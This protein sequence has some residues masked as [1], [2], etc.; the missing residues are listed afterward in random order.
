[1]ITGYN[2]PTKSKTNAILS[3]NPPLLTTLPPHV[4]RDMMC[5]GT[6]IHP[7]PKS[8]TTETIFYKL[9]GQFGQDWPEV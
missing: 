7:V 8:C 5:K 9:K 6:V 3:E 1:M 4:V 2:Q